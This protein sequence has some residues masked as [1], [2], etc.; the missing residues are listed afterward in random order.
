MYLKNLELPHAEII[1]CSRELGDEKKGLSIEF[2]LDNYSI[3]KEIAYSGKSI[4]IERAIKDKSEVSTEGITNYSYFISYEHDGLKS[5]LALIPK[6]NIEERVLDYLSTHNGYFKID[7]YFRD[8]FG[9]NMKVDFISRYSSHSKISSRIKRLKV[10]SDLYFDET[11]TCQT[12]SVPYM[13]IKLAKELEAAEDL[14]IEKITYLYPFG[15]G[16][17]NSEGKDYDYALSFRYHGMRDEIY[18]DPIKEETERLLKYLSANNK[19][20]SY[21]NIRLNEESHSINVDFRLK[22]EILD[23][24][25]NGKKF[26]R[27]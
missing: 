9:S 5:R 14:K 19:E 22:Y 26:R 2:H 4:K 21:G 24:Y 6:D 23:L 16:Y 10:E 25:L 13:P 1:G 7:A 3:A 18:L 17:P 27:S 15:N 11:D 20:F 12:L 8:I